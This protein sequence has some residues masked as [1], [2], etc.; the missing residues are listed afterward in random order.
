MN[1]DLTERIHDLSI[2][3]NKIL[4][5]DFSA[6]MTL[7]SHSH[8]H[9]DEVLHDAKQTQ[10]AMDSIGTASKGLKGLPSG[11]LQMVKDTFRGSLVEFHFET[12][13]FRNSYGGSAICSGSAEEVDTSLIKQSLRTVLNQYTH[14]R[15][16]IR[17]IGIITV[18]STTTTFRD[19]DSQTGTP[20][21]STVTQTHVELFPNPEFLYVGVYCSFV[22]QG[23][24]TFPARI[25]P[26]LRVYHIVDSSAPIIRA[27][28]NG[29]VQTVQKLFVNE[30]ASPFDRMW[31]DTSLL[32]LVMFRIVLSAKGGL[33]RAQMPKLLDLFKELVDYGLDPGMVRRIDNMTSDGRLPLFTLSGLINDCPVDLQPYLIELGRTIITKSVHDP[34][35]DSDED[36]SLTYRDPIEAP[37]Q[38]LAILLTQEWPITLEEI[39]ENSIRL[40]FKDGQRIQNNGTYQGSRIFWF[41]SFRVTRGIDGLRFTLEGCSTLDEK[42]NILANIRLTRVF[43]GYTGLPADEK[44][45]IVLENWILLCLTYCIASGFDPREPPLRFYPIIE[46]FRKRSKLYLLC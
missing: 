23:F 42:L 1:N 17:A 8:S 20:T 44:N 21:T 15:R 33:P 37:P 40:Y 43:N 2:G 27:C 36:M 12:S 14:V 45:D 22:L 25:E 6:S 9:V 11:M 7:I 18:Y 41:S 4:S 24:A 31:R 30:E 19:Q 28:A 13:Q 29:D 3:I 16:Y 46:K 39:S 32:D 26:N 35:F 5:K 10:A 38:I 34:L